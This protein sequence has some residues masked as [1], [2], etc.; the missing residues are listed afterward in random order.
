M[1]TV[2]TVLGPLDTARL[3]FTLSHEHVMV[4]AA[5]ILQAYPEFLDR[6]TTIEQAVKEL[7]EA[8]AGGVHTIVDMTTPDLGRDVR[9]LEEVSGRS[10][11]NIIATTGT[12]V[13]IPRVFWNADPDRIAALYVREIRVGMDGTDSKAGVIKVANNN[14]E[15]TPQEVIII[16]AAARAHKQTGAPIS[17]HTRSTERVGESQVRVFEEEGVDLS[18]VCIGHS[19]DTTD[20]DYLLGLLR[21][22]VY[23]SLD[24]H[25]GGRAGPPDWQERTAIAKRLMD[26]GYAHRLMFGHDMVVRVS[27]DDPN[28][29][30]ERLAYNPDSY[31][32]VARKVLP[33]LRELG[34]SERDI[35][36]V[37]VDNPRRFFEGN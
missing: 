37:T 25:P 31:L 16:R 14:R 27:R 6:E 4:S 23:L 36:A 33:R 9:L 7:R 3:G 11:V 15:L 26:A 17:T 18:R 20:V 29:L 12:W 35:Q 30:R 24:H 13:D 21:K 1:A 8:N 5:G 19:N 28:V 34:A 32:F 2:N 22:G 10:R